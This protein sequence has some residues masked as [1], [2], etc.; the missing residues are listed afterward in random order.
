MKSSAT[1]CLVGMGYVG[2]PLAE[3][4]AAH[5][6]VI[7]YDIDTGKVS[8]L[9]KSAG[10][11]PITYTDSPSMI[12]RADFI[13][14]CVPTPLTRSSEPDL[15]HVIS[16]A[17]TIGR[18]MK[19]GATVVLES[20][21]YPGVT[22]EIVRPVL[23]S[24]S[25]LK[26][27]VDFKLAYSP[28][29]INPGDKE[30]SVDKVTK[31]VA[32]MDQETTRAVAQLYGQVTP[33]IHIASEI[34]IAEAA[35]VIENIQRDLNI[36]LV[37]ELSIIFERLGLNT[38]EVLDAAA[39]KW[40]FHRYNPGLVGGHCIPVDPHYLVYKARESGYHPQVILAGR[41]IN[42]YMPKHVAGLIIKALN[43]QGK[44][45]KDSRVLILGLTYKED[46]PDIRESPVLVIIKELQEYGVQVLGYDPLLDTRALKGKFNIDILN[47][48]E[49]RQLERNKVDCVVLTVAHSYFK[50]LNLLDLRKMQGKNPILIDVRQIYSKE[51]A[52]K[53]GFY[54][55]AL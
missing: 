42:D 38:K 11:A 50:K 1:I 47:E 16:A 46:V 28:E 13:I 15:S 34:K 52:K 19:K 22:E 27:G 32:G 6:P 5:F 8:K 53:E 25:G 17:R 40:N 9:K 31:I 33:H 45:I 18:H 51:E 3:A 48:S 39:T 14:I 21:V 44:V 26:A 7:G 49:L 35:K 4:F 37:N 20:T 36:A 10:K 29:R 12:N 2:L 55:K 23:E 24:E 41:A 54:Y 30:H 43:E